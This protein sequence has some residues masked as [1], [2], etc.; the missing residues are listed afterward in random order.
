VRFRQ[1][2]ADW[3]R[4]ASARHGD[5]SEAGTAHLAARAERLARIHPTSPLAADAMPE[6]RGAALER[7]LLLVDAI[8]WLGLTPKS[9]AL[10]IHEVVRRGGA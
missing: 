8:T 3:W 1:G 2:R 10:S 7:V 4:G 5:V 9:Q 6:E